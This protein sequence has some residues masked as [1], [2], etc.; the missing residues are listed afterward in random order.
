MGKDYTLIRGRMKA[1]L[2]FQAAIGMI[3]RYS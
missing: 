2:A 1:E 3:G